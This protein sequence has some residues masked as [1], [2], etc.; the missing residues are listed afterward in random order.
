MK[1]KLCSMIAGFVLLAG[2]AET[3]SADPLLDRAPD[4]QRVEVRRLEF[5]PVSFSGIG[6]V[7]RV[8]IR[9]ET[10]W[11]AFWTRLW[12]GDRRPRP[13]VDF[14]REMVVA[15]TMGGRPTGGF[16]IQVDSAVVSS[17]AV[18]V[19]VTEQSPGR[20]CGTTQAFVYPA[21]AVA[22]PASSQPVRFHEAK[23]TRE[24]SP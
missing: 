17:A 11:P 12:G 15:A 7:E 10:E 5:L 2:C 24:C 4:A 19:F 22:I 9:S 21:D 20:S 6:T 18:D 16:W 13:A 23:V 3:T 1:G 8:V 14:D